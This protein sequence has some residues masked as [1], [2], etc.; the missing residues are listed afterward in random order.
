P[1]LFKRELVE[2]TKAL[3]VERYHLYGQSWGGMLAMEHALTHPAGLAS[4][5]VADSPASIPLWVEETAKLRADL[6]ADVQEVLD[7]HEAAGT[8]EDPEYIAAAFEFYER[9]VCRLDP[10]PEE[11]MRSFGALM[12]DNTVYSAMWGPSEFTCT[13]SLADWDI[14]DRLGG[15]DVPTLIISGRYDE[16]TPV[17][18]E[19]I[20]KGIADSE[21][22][23]FENSSHTPHL[24]EKDAVLTAVGKFLDRVDE[25]GG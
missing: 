13:G 21:W 15:I 2:L 16:A 24:E 11:L 4:I 3:G 6:P 20:H 23:L 17:V 12:E 25:H 8:T 9:H 14:T 22:L 18:V 1:E 5:I 10:M 19:P 7:R